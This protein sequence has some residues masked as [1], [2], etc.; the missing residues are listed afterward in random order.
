MTQSI[1]VVKKSVERAAF[2]TKNFT[3]GMSMGVGVGPFSGRFGS[4]VFQGLGYGYSDTPFPRKSLYFLHLSNG[5]KVEVSTAVFDKFEVGDV[6]GENHAA[7]LD[8]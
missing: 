6:F 8:F 5:R 2:S 1:T 4:S 7:S 3:Y